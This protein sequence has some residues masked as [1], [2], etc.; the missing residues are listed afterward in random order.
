[1]R[2]ASGRRTVDYDSDPTMASSVAQF[3]RPA[4]RQGAAIVVATQRH[5]DAF[6]EALQAA[7][8][9]MSDA[10]QAGRLTLLDAA[11]TLVQLSVNGTP[12]R[13]RFHQVVGDLLERASG[14]G[15]PVRVFSGMAA[16]LYEDG[17]VAESIVLEGFWNEI[18]AVRTFDLL[19]AYP[20]RLFSGGSRPF[21]DICAQH[22]AVAPRLEHDQ[23]LRDEFNASMLHELRSPI[24][25]IAGFLDTLRRSW[26]ELDSGEIDEFLVRTIAN[27]ERLKGLTNELLA[28]MRTE[29]GQFASQL[30]PVDLPA[31]VRRAAEE[32]HAATGRHI[33]LTVTDEAAVPAL[34]DENRQLQILHNL[35]TN[36]V[37]FS[38]PDSAITVSVARGH[39]C[40]QVRT[41]MKAQ[42]SRPRQ[43]RDC[44]AR[45][46]GWTSTAPPPGRAWGCTLPGSSSRLRGAGSGWRA[47]QATVRPSSTPSSRPTRAEGAPVPALKTLPR[48]RGK[49]SKASLSDPSTRA[50]ASG[51]TR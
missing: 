18:A 46:H 4:L 41:T 32:V 36:A 42:A 28:M 30:R 34:A 29:A 33:D 39:G 27:T 19:C 49:V 43:C 9:E 6:G 23:Q 16:L 35:L 40:L 11:E 1:L 24:T 8:V 17:R 7:D 15:G 31:I 3:L 38:S 22:T 13:D 45:S 14:D 51:G 12:D 21:Q 25:V 37:K 47:A 5:R 48:M 26:R 20:E 2:S 10:V 50:G 44:S